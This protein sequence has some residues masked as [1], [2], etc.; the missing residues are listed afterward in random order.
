MKRTLLI[1][2]LVAPIA[3]VAGIRAQAVPGGGLSAP[4]CGQ[5]AG[6]DPADAEPPVTTPSGLV[7]QVVNRGAGPAARPGQ[8]V[9]IHETLTLADGTV[10]FSTRTKDQPVKFRLGGKQVIDGVD[11]GVTGMKVG[12][13]RKLIIP[14]VLSR[15]SVPSAGI[16]PDAT[17][18][19]EVE[20][21]E[22]VQ[23]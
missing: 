22:I 18:Y 5:S 23:E 2:T 16:S 19:Y 14:P 11:E 8:H 21:V 17:L 12:E 1:G 7:Y 9:V 4:H 20:L 10:V 3:I 13:R 15:R 6:G